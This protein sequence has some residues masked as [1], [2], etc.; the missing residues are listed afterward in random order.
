M[1]FRSELNYSKG[2]Q[3]SHEMPYS[4]SAHSFFPDELGEKRYYNPGKAGKERAAAQRLE[5]IRSR[6]SRLREKDKGE[7]G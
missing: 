4:L 5:E 3:Y 1:L 7:K 6:I 2:Y